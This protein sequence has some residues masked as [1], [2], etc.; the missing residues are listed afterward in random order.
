MRVPKYIEKIIFNRALYA[1]KILTL[2]RA[3][4]DWLKKNDIEVETYDNLGGCEM[5]ANPFSS[6]ERIKKA[7]ERK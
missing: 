2:D 1:S 6:S 5:Y 4:T 7:I 3:L